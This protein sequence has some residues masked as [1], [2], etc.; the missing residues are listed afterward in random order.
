MNTASSRLGISCNHCHK[1]FALKDAGIA[2][3]VEAN[4]LPDPFP[5][6]CPLCGAEGAYA[7]ASIGSIV[8]GGFMHGGS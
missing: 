8:P 6:K 2:A 7:K 1:S 5:L 4:A 3:G